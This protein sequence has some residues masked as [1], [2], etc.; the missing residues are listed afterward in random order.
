MKL[1]FSAEESA[2][3]EMIE[4]IERQVDEAMAGAVQDAAEI[5]VAEGRSNIT[6]AGFSGRWQNALQSKFFPNKG[7]DP[8]ALIF[9]SMPLA[10][11]FERGVR[12]SGRPLLWL[13]IKKNLPA[14]VRSPRKYGRK[15]VSVNVAGKPP[16]L[17]DAADRKRGPLFFGTP[18]VTIRKRFDLLRIFARA[19]ERMQEFYEQRIK[20]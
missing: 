18:A 12:I 11:V 16:L 9:H 2:I 8:G 17:F 3:E 20:G 10:G 19:A 14:G 1:V 15:L 6:G 13:P 7:G 5:A 4:E